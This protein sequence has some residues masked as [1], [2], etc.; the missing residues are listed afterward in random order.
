M[1]MQ[2]DSSA[3]QSNAGLKRFVSGYRLLPG[4][5]DEMMDAEGRVRP[6]WRPFLDRKSVV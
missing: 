5:F 3:E 4:V 6:H 1:S 2:L